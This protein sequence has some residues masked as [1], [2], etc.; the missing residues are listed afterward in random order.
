[1]VCTK[2]QTR[3]P[4][5]ELGGRHFVL[6]RGWRGGAFAF[7]GEDTPYVPDG[8]LQPA[9]STGDEALGKLTRSQ[10]KKSR[11]ISELIE[12]GDIR[13]RMDG[14]KKGR[15]LTLIREKKKQPRRNLQV[16]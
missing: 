8:Y 16:L 7:E 6:G 3:S 12:A 15:Y 2:T 14:M 10:I 1:M 5:G 13:E 11:L 4:T 9:P